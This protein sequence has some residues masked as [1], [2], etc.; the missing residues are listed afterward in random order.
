MKNLSTSGSLPL[1]ATSSVCI[2]TEGLELVRLKNP[3]PTIFSVFHNTTHTI[4][5]IYRFLADEKTARLG[6]RM[7]ELLRHNPD[8]I[9]ICVGAL[10]D[11]MDV[12]AEIGEEKA[13]QSYMIDDCNE[14]G[15]FLSVMTF[16][17][18]ILQ[19]T[20][21]MLIRDSIS[22]RF[23]E[24]D[25]IEKC[26]RLLTLQLQP[27]YCA[28]AC[29]GTVDRW[30]FNSFYQPLSCIDV[31]FRVF[32]TL[33]TTPSG[34]TNKTEKIIMLFQEKLRDLL[35]S[36]KKDMTIYREKY[37]SWESG[38]NAFSE[39]KKQMGVEVDQ[40]V[41]QYEDQVPKYTYTH[42][43]IHTYAHIHIHIH[44]HTCTHTPMCSHPHIH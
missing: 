19:V 1:A 23:V 31:S 2:T 15:G 20:D 25:G 24:L 42:T 18:S 14:D 7:E 43:H 10:V 30:P 4:E 6:V 32:E 28:L 22:N 41:D 27:E 29:L 36:I 26:Y 40:N 8:L 17:H 35:E 3:F 34:T 39:F 5:P 38:E 13:K 9:D 11:T 21:R 12:I 16:A 37:W 44:I 33:M